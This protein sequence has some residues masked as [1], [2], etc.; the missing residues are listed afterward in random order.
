MDIAVTGAS[1]LIGTTLVEALTADGHRPVRLVR[2]SPRP[3]ED[4]ISWDPAAGAIDA[5]SLEGIDAVV[6]LAGEGIAEKRWNPAQKARILDSRV[7]GT[8]LLATT[9][10]G[11]DKRP[12]VLLSGSAIGYYG[13]RGDEEL[14]EAS[15]PGD[16]F[17]ADVCKA[18]EAATATAEAAGIRVAHLRTG[19]VLDAHG[20]AL[21]KTL[22]L[23][24]LGLGGRLGSGKQWWSW[25]SADDEVGA[26]RFLLHA[27]VSGPVNLT[28]PQPVTNAEFTKVL[29]QVLGRPTLLPVPAFGP[30]VLLGGEL[31]EQLL[32]TSAR[33]LP[34]ALTDAGYQFATPD[35]ESGLRKVLGR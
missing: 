29:G 5:D 25:I 32:F 13:D 27:D 10:A 6:H 22:P 24:K 2:R 11:L 9:L 34:M 4:A 8:T 15:P 28:A 35:L 12:A 23:F 31:A 33:V 20:G 3:G 16:I 21:A 1:G 18:W 26:I 30:K 7:D 17:L 19:I 14:T